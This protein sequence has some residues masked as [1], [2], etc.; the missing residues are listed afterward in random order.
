MAPQKAVWFKD[1]QEEGGWELWCCW[2][3]VLELWPE[4]LLI[5]NRFVTVQWPDLG[6]K[7]DK[8][9]RILVWW[10]GKGENWAAAAVLV[11]FR[12]GRLVKMSFGSW[13]GGGRDVHRAGCLGAKK[14]GILMYS[15]ANTAWWRINCSRGEFQHKN[16]LYLYIKQSYLASPHRSLLMTAKQKAWSLFFTCCLKPCA[17]LANINANGCLILYMEC[18]GEVSRWRVADRCLHCKSLHFKQLPCFQRAPGGGKGLRKFGD[19]FPFPSFSVR[20]SK[21]WCMQ[22]VWGSNNSSIIP[23]IQALKRIEFSTSVPSQTVPFPKGQ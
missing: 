11:V 15:G 9:R 10:C 1:I 23:D 17:Y 14:E 20:L 22:M 8:I 19:S 13:S 7:D 6:G 5:I 16:V 4:A 18:A 21:C 3:A 12:T 2:I